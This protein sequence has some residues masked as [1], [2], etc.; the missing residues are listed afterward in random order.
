MN[1]PMERQQDG[2]KERKK[3]WA[4]VDA[5]KTGSACCGNCAACS[6]GS[7]GFGMAVHAKKY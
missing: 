1:Q 6:F 5:K 4:V 3:V 7:A 2:M